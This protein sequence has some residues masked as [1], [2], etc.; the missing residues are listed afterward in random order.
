LAQLF[1][2]TR[3]TIRKALYQLAAI[4]VVDLRPNRGAVVASPGIEESRQIFAARR[5]IECA[6]VETIA[7]AHSKATVRRLKAMIRRENQAYQRID[8]K[9]ALRLSV[10]FHREL[11]NVAG[12]AVMAEI[13]ERLISQ[14]PL[15]LLAWRDP[16]QT[17]SCMNAD[18]VELVAA[19]EDGDVLRASELMRCHLCNLEGQ[20]RL[21][22]VEPAQE[23]ARIFGRDPSNTKPAAAQ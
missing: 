22:K 7:K 8:T 11:A 9:Q 6:L 14:T 18:H 15:V 3:G 1:G 2:V 13:L 5:A 4:R 23:L 12:N 21:Q 20:L 17:G 19:I 10:D 16:G